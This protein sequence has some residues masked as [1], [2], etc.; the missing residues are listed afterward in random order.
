MYT[1]SYYKKVF[2]FYKKIYNYI[3]KISSPHNFVLIYKNGSRKPYV[4]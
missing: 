2:T 3:K 1:Q 4:L